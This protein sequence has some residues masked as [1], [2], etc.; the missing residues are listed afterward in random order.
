M[1]FSQCASFL[2]PRKRFCQ[3]SYLLLFVFKNSQIV[4]GVL[5]IVYDM[6]TDD[7]SRKKHALTNLGAEKETFKTWQFLDEQKS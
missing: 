3:Q 6:L 2:Y 5:F 7:D 4:F 1:Y